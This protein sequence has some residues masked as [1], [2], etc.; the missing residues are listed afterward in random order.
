MPGEGT[1]ISIPERVTNR[2]SEDLIGE[3]F[4]L[5]QYFATESYNNAK[6]YMVQLYELVQTLALPDLSGVG[7]VE[8]PEIL[9]LDFTKRPNIAALELD[10]DIPS[11]D[12]AAPNFVSVPTI[13]TFNM[14]TIGFSPP[15]WNALNKPVLNEI[16]APPDIPSISVPTIPTMPTIKLP[17][18]PIL[19]SITI[20]A[21]PESILPVFDAQRPTEELNLPEPFAYNEPIYQSD[22]WTELMAKILDD[23]RNGGTGLAIDVEES[24]WT[25][26]RM[27][28]EDERAAKLRQVEQKFGPSGFNLP[29]GAFVGALLDIDKE[30]IRNL[31][32][33]GIDISVEQAKLAQTNSQFI[34]EQGIKCEE[35][36]RKFFN[37]QNNRILD[38][39]KQIAL[40][41]IEVFK[42]AVELHNAR[43]EQY[44]AEAAV[45]ESRVRA[46]QQEIELFKS[47]VEA[48][49]VSAE[50]QAL[51]VDIYQKQV[52]A[53]ES[54][55][56]IYATQL[57]SAK[58]Q[59]DV[60][61]S[62]IQ[63][64]K[65]YVD[66]YIARLGGEKLKLEI[67]QTELDGER[68]KSDIYK[69]Q[70]EAFSASVSAE[71]KRTDANIAI[72]DSTIKQNNAKVELYKADLYAYSTRIDA[73]LK[74]ISAKVTGFTAEVSAYSAETSAETAYYGVKEAEI[75]TRIEAATMKLQKAIAEIEAVTKG[76]TSLNALKLEGVKG[77]MDVS[78][79][80]TSAAL[81]AVHASV[82]RG[83][84]TSYGWSEN[85]NESAHLSE[86][87][88][89]DETPT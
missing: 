68:A 65:V 50:V 7:E 41:G 40:V 74:A 45:F 69:S 55:I 14:P 63:A 26:A 24:I 76:Y 4:D 34:V 53:V 77:I 23:I 88:N 3:R 22:M 81:A 67:Y 28:L 66:A 33:A 85:F 38:A 60:N 47:K 54:Q 51:L 32:T 13:P 31:R 80:L 58:I 61:G 35:I 86:S 72:A 44:K 87:H 11:P 10:T 48:S 64:Y 57:E 52:Q 2:G 62:T 49:K 5:S 6:L 20:P 46:A 9:P 56:K 84:N 25:R 59:A 19:A 37:D 30:W 43:V 42:S 12:I 1:Y 17:D 70:V 21:A 89:F 75:R 36:L 16:T 71:A 39:N 15:Q 83:H 8:I 29:Q 78:A 73:L 27:R 18:A 82:S 79:Q